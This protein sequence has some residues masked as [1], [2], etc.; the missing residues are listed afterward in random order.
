MSNLLA[1][2]SLDQTAIAFRF[3]PADR[4]GSWRIDD[5]YLDPFCKG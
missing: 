4:L 5:V 3:T 2:V 1:T